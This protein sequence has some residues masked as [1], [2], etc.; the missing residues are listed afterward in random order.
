MLYFHESTFREQLD[1]RKDIADYR[2]IIPVNH[3]L[4]ESDA[5]E[6]LDSLFSKEKSEQIDVDFDL[7]YNRSENEFSFSIETSSKDINEALVP[8]KAETWR[9]MSLI[10]KEK[11]IER[12]KGAVGTCLDISECPRIAYYIS[13]EDDC[14][15]YDPSRNTIG[16]NRTNMDDAQSIVNTIS[17]EMRHAYQKERIK[18]LETE[19]D[20]LYMLNFENYIS[21]IEINGGYV[22][23]LDYQNQLVE[24]EARAFA[25]LFFI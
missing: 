5:I 3:A 25:N 9:Y 17:H 11:A 10:E 2:L 4:H 20:Y 12:F 15:Y 14:G 21:P 18:I 24:A 6:F 7:I 1:N 22:G 19:M 13:P 16:I 23:F 8:F